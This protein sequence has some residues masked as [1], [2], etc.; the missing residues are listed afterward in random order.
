[1]RPSFGDSLDTH[2]QVEAAVAV[3]PSSLVVTWHILANDQDDIGIDWFTRA[4]GP[5]LS[6]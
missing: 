5:D 2:R 4:S 1:L 3:G 6:P